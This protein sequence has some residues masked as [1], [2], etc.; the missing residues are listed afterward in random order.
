VV[1]RISAASQ[2]SVKKIE[3][4]GIGFKKKKD[5]GRSL[6]SSAISNAF[7]LNFKQFL[8]IDHFWFL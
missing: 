5:I 3:N 1:N 2:I 7:W 8:N 4:I 6:V